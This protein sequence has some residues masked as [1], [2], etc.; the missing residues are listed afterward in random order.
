[1]TADVDALSRRFGKLIATH[2]CIAAILKTRD[3]TNRP[4]AYDISSFES[5]SKLRKKPSPIPSA[6]LPILTSTYITTAHSPQVNIAS[7]HNAPCNFITMPTNATISPCSLP[8][9]PTN[10][11]NMSLMSC[12]IQFIDVKPIVPSS[13]YASD[14]K[15]INDL[16]TH[17]SHWIS[18][19]DIL[20]SNLSWIQSSPI[21]SNIWRHKFYFS[22][23]AMAS[24]FSLLHP[25]QPH[26]IHQ[27]LNLAPVLRALGP[28]S[29]MDFTCI[30]TSYDVLPWL[31]QTSGLLG[32]VIN[33][34]PTFFF[35]LVWV[36]SSHFPPSLWSQCEHIFASSLPQDWCMHRFQL[37]AIFA[38]DAV[39]AQ[40][41]LLL[42]H[43]VDNR[44][45]TATFDSPVSHISPPSIAASTHIH[46]PN[47]DSI[48]QFAFATKE[49]SISYNDC[50]ITPRITHVIVPSSSFANVSS[51][52][53]ILDSAFPT[54]EPVAEHSS[55]EY[56]G[57]RS[58]LCLSTPTSSTTFSRSLSNIELLL[59]YS[60]PYDNV[61]PYIDDTCYTNQLDDLLPHCIPFH[62]RHQ[63]TTAIINSST[64]LEMHAASTCEHVDNLQCYLTRQ[65][66]NTLE[67][68]Q[69]HIIRTNLQRLCY[70]SYHL[71][72]CQ[73]TTSQNSHQLN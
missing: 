16:A 41:H 65:H 21:Y 2:L 18:I 49:Y 39:S 30:P 32:E 54:F 40:R 31:K 64:I 63:T 27:Y 28:M 9:L 72:L 7:S 1:M 11:Y 22:S 17:F 66:R 59:C 12:P 55:N 62:L 26:S 13:C 45:I 44:H 48:T 60:I 6:P 50:D 15:D 42:I 14:S 57:R 24:T 53:Y 47:Q 36:S 3:T 33:S 68:G 67:T 46:Q 69:K 43:H 25:G 19:D 70:P 20:G 29:V 51:S 56:L 8:P 61:H 4:F 38:G 34:N 73:K 10:T 23:N 37:N 5:F 35:G 52:N 58:G 71:H